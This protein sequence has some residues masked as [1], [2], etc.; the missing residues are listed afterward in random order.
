MQTKRIVGGNR[1]AD[2]FSIN[3]DHHILPMPG[4]L[5][6]VVCHDTFQILSV[7]LIGKHP[8]VGAVM[9]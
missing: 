5:R 4:Q 7:N 3:S 8:P 6:Q 1:T 2:G 9:R